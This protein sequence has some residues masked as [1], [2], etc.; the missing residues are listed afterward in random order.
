MGEALGEDVSEYS[1]L[2]AAG[3]AGSKATCLTGSTSCRR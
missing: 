1:M 2:F 3:K